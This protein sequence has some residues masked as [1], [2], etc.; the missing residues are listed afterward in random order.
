M[1]VVKLTSAEKNQTAEI[2]LKD[3]TLT[4]RVLLSNG[5]ELTGWQFDYAAEGFDAGYAAAAAAFEVD[6]FER[7]GYVQH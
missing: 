6:R 7:Y 1:N 3:E 5:E 2:K 4:V